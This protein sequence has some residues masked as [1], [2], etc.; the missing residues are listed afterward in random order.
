MEKGALLGTR[1]EEMAGEI[2]VEGLDGDIEGLITQRKLFRAS[3]ALFQPR[4]YRVLKKH[5]L[6]PLLQ[7]FPS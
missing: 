7:T 3:L 6:F 1:V 4:K 5:R 2:V